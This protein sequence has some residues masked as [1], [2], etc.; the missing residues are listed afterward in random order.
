MNKRTWYFTFG[1]QYLHEP[2]PQGGHPDGWFE[3]TAGSE[4]QA[5]EKMFYECGPKWSMVYD[6]QPSLS[7]FP[8][9]CLKAF[10]V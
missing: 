1:Q 3:V 4:E 5:R 7:I 9:G 10:D 6:E 2:H 8:L